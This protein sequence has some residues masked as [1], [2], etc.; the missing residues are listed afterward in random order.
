MPHFPLCQ[1]SQKPYYVRPKVC[2]SSV[3]VSN[4][5]KWQMTRENCWN[6]PRIYQYCY[7]L[8]PSS[9]WNLES[10][11]FNSKVFNIYINICFLS[12]YCHFLDLCNNPEWKHRI[13]FF[14]NRLQRSLVWPPARNWVSCE[15]RPIS[16]VFIWLH[17]HSLQGWRLQ[18]VSGEPFFFTHLDYK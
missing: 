12:K 1:P 10:K 13:F 2:M 4:H 8:K 16:Q 15:I 18:T 14:F 5:G 3:F 6:G 17:L 11:I 7:K 9:F